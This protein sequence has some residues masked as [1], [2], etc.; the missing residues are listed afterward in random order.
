MTGMTARNF[1]IADRGLLQDRRDGRRGGVRPGAHRRHRDLRPADQRQ[2]RH[3]RGV[4]QRP[5]APIAAATTAR[6]W[7]VP[8][9][10]SSARRAS[11]EASPAHLCAAGPGACLPRRALETAAMVPICRIEPV[12]IGLRPVLSQNGGHAM[13][14]SMLNYPSGLFGHFERLRRELDDVFGG[15]AVASSIRSVAAG[16]LPAINVGRTPRQRGGVCLR[17]RPGR[18]ED[19]GHARPRRAAHRRRT[20]FGDPARTTTRSPS[21]RASATAG[22]FLRAVSLPDDV[23]PAQRACQLQGW[24]AAGE[25]RTPRSRPT[26]AHHGAVTRTQGDRS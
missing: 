26:Q 15:S 21:T 14:E 9:A 7:P 13:Y 20:R 6:C 23:D 1:R 19:R 2:P 12:E 10:C 18:V 22:R 4:R 8:V 24:R 5:P 3:R 17:A 11:A 16:T 25:H